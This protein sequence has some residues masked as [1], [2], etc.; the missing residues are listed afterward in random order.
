[1]GLQSFD[2]SMDGSADDTPKKLKSTKKKNGKLTKILSTDFDG[3][4]NVRACSYFT[5]CIDFAVSAFTCT[6]YF[7]FLFSLLFVHRCRVCD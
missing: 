5:T 3:D 7:E 6:A 1:M 2:M 4:S